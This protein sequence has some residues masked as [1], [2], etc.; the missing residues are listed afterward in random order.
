VQATWVPDRLKRGW[1]SAKS[2]PRLI[3]SVAVAVLLV[4]MMISSPGQSQAAVGDTSTIDPNAPTTTIDPNAPTTTVDPNAP[5]TTTIAGATTTAPG[6]TTTAAGATTTT[7]VTTTTTTIAAV[8]Q[9]RPDGLDCIQ[10]AMSVGYTDVNGDKVLDQFDIINVTVTVTALRGGVS[11]PVVSIPLPLG[12]GHRFVAGSLAVNGT[13]AGTLGASVATVALPS[14]L[15]GTSTVTVGI[16]LGDHVPPDLARAPLNLT[17]QLTA[18]DAS[19]PLII[20]LVSNQLEVAQRITD[21]NV[22]LRVTARPTV[23]GTVSFQADITNQG[24]DTATAGSAVFQLP[25]V[26]DLTTVLLIPGCRL[27]GVVVSCA[28]GDIPVTFV[29]SPLV[30]FRLLPTAVSG[31][32]IDV[33]VTVTNTTEGELRR[34]RRTSRRR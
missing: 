8:P 13:T 1:G 6:A 25:P 10:S 5:T 7:G 23:G 30:S 28:L 34:T 33:S 20:S 11:S 18:L 31:S 4:G 17:S 22:T 21:L 32:S 19:Q 9:C 3:G 15:S 14:P 29:A 12:S 26:A 16:V 27:S 2:A 24:P